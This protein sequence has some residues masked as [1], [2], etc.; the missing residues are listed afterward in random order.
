MARRRKPAPDAPN[1][2]L[3]VDK[4]AGM[5]STAVSNVLKHMSLGAK[6]GHGGTLDP[7]ATGILPIALG[8]ATKTVPYVTDALKAYLFTVR[9][10]QATHT[11]DAEGAGIAQADLRPTDYGSKAAR[12]ALVIGREHV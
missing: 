11:D 4:P 8:A 1:G 7:M 6:C 12:N 3:V 5:T 2:W 9:F 10:G